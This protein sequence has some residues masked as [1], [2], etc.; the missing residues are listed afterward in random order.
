MTKKKVVAKKP[1][2]ALV[3]EVHDPTVLEKIVAWLAKHG[4]K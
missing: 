3:I 4:V 2:P 1:V